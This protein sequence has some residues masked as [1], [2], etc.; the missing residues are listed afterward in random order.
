MYFQTQLIGFNQS[1]VDVGGG[2]A[3]AP[4]S[5]RNSQEACNAFI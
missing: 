4:A 2:K 5:S 3:L 1:E